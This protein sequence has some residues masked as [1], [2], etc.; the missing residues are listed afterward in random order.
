MM[1]GL[2][3]NRRVA[4]TKRN[5]PETGTLILRTAHRLNETMH[6]VSVYKLGGSYVIKVSRRTSHCTAA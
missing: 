1:I 5:R 3:S 4:V 6:V 2:P